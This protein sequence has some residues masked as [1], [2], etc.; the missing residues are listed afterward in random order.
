MKG[1]RKVVDLIYMD[2]IK[3]ESELKRDYWARINTWKGWMNDMLDKV[4]N[5]DVYVEEQTEYFTANNFLRDFLIRRFEWVMESISDQELRIKYLLALPPFNQIGSIKRFFLHFFQ[6]KDVSQQNRVQFQFYNFSER[7]VRILWDMFKVVR[8][9]ESIEILSK[10]IAGSRP[11]NSIFS[12]DYILS[13]LSSL[14]KALALV[15]K[16]CLKPEFHNQV[17]TDFPRDCLE[18]EAV[19]NR[20]MSEDYMIN[21]LVLEKFDYRNYFFHIYFRSSLKAIYK[22]KDLTF[23]FNYLDYEIV[24][25]EFLID[26]INNRLANSPIKIH[27][28]E[29]YTI[30]RKTFQEVIDNNPEMEITLL[31]RLPKPVFDALIAEVSENVDNEDQAPVDPMSEEVGEYAQTFRLFQKAKEIAEK[32]IEAVRNLFSSSDDEYDDDEFENDE[33]GPEESEFK[34]R[35]LKK[36]E[37]DFP[38]FCPENS[39]FSKQMSLLQAKMPS[40]LFTR[41]NRKV[42]DYLAKVSESH[43]IKR[44]TPRHEWTAPYM[45]NEMVGDESHTY[46]LI[47]GAEVKNKQLSMGYGKGMEEKFDFKPYFVFGSK[48]KM[49]SMGRTMETRKVTGKVIQVYSNSNQNVIEKVM[50]LLDL[51]IEN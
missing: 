31:K 24:R 28:L 34:V 46:L 37:I 8:T 33:L 32:S 3:I 2:S 1:N 40:D 41:F 39:K 19:L 18:P 38:Y 11:F 17:L 20:K 21:D 14:S 10:H 48:S 45:I 13:S 12:K 16:I 50:E 6:F 27:V 7:E 15:V 4:V 44:R 43:L 35:N 42:G 26:W 9:L 29:S 36:S 5:E 25:Q 22:G 51:V 30:G 47:L 23:K 49:I